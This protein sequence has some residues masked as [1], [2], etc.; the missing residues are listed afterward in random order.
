MILFSIIALLFIACAGS[1]FLLG[2]RTQK[3]AQRIERE[4][5]DAEKAKTALLGY[6]IVD[7]CTLPLPTAEWKVKQVRFSDAPT[8]QC[9]CLV[10]GPVTVSDNLFI[11]VDPVPQGLP[12]TAATNAYAL[13]VW[14]MHRNRSVQASIA[15]GEA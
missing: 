5:E 11:Y 12:R 9:T 3:R 1:F 14:T 15:V 10:V 7:G 8:K 6:V 13:S 2:V 4:L